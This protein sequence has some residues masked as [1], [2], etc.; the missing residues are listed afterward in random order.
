MN[1]N[2]LRAPNTARG[3]STRYVFSILPEG[4]EQYCYYHLDSMHSNIKTLGLGP[5]LKISTAPSIIGIL[6][7]SEGSI[8]NTYRVEDPE[9]SI[10]R[11][12]MI[13][14]RP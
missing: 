9:G 7:C 3:S 12:E 14:I 6:L 4:K 11:S 10:G 2:R 8:E 13:F 1:K 5:M